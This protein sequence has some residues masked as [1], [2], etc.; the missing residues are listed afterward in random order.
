MEEFNEMYPVFITT[1]LPV[2]LH[3]MFCVFHICRK[4]SYTSK[5]T[6]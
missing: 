1:A 3:I 4:R 2:L 5:F 6:Q